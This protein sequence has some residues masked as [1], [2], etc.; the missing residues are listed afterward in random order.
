V[1]EGDEG[2]EN[3]SHCND[4]IEGVEK[5]LAECREI[6]AEVPGLREM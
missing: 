4:R 1:Y 6:T 5:E 2:D 3:K